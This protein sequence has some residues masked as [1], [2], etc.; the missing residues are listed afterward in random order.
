MSTHSVDVIKVE[1]VL[2]HPN[3]DSLSIINVLGFTCCVGLDQFLPGD[4]V[5]YIEPD[6]VVNTTHPAFTFMKGWSKSGVGGNTDLYRVGVKKLRGVMSQG[7]IIPA[8]PGSRV[9]DNVMDTLGITRYEPPLNLKAGG[10]CEKP[11]LKHS[12]CYDIENWRR[13]QHLLKPGEEVVV[14]EK[15]HGANARFC[16]QPEN[17]RMYCGSRVEWKKQDECNLWWQ[18]LKQNLWIE[19]FCRENPEVVLYGE[20]FGQVA[21]LKY[22]AEKGDVFVRAFDILVGNQYLSWEDINT[23]YP[24]ILSYWVPIVMTGPYNPSIE[25]L[26]E[27]PSLVLGSGHLREGVVVQPLEERTDPSIGRVKL[28]IVGNG[29]LSRKMGRK[30]KTK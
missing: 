18:A 26:A 22:G 23:K 29:F 17:D 10:E 21:D 27:G 13:H 3:A 14:T 28:K 30:G 1:E 4:L 19:E 9:G 7:I 12:V 24:Q 5:A 20:V 8:P 2:P 25:E 15:I 16:Y 11:P 6:M